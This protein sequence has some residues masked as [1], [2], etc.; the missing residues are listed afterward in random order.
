MKRRFWIRTRLFLRQARW[1]FAV[2]GAWFLLGTLIFRHPGGL[3]YREAILN[4]IYVKKSAAGEVWELYSFWGQ[5]VLF[6]IVISI[7]FCRR[8]SAITRRRDAACWQAK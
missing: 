8:C 5:C 1:G 7:F 3:S 2:I 6:G 4:A